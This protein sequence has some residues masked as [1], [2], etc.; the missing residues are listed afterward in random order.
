[1]SQVRDTFEDVV[2]A[3]T[4]K[5]LKELRSVRKRRGLSQADVAKAIDRSQDTVSRYERPTSHGTEIR[6]I[7]RF[8]EGAG[9]RL[10][11]V[12]VDRLDPEASPR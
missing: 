4:T 6:S 10:L 9:I 3:R 2:E 1:M 12:D 11:P 7:V 8:C 5:L